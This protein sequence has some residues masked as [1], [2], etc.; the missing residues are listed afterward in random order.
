MYCPVSWLGLGHPCD[1]SMGNELEIQDLK[2][3]AFHHRKKVPWV[4]SCLRTVRHMEQNLIQPTTSW[5]SILY[6]LTGLRDAQTAGITLFLG[7]SLRM[8]LEDISVWI[9]KLSKEYPPS[10]MWAGVLQSSEDPN[11]AKQWRKGE[12]K[13]SLLDPECPPSPALNHQSTRFSVWRPELNYTTGFPGSPVRRP[14]IMGLLS[15]YNLM[16]QF[17]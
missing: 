2:Q 8:F 14:H 16:S 7:V 13:L 5:L 11:R 9:T 1:L 12:F 15:S 10:P 4:T 6:N 17:P 3:V